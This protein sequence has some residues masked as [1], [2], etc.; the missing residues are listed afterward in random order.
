MPRRA[1]LGLPPTIDLPLRLRLA[2][3]A[4]LCGVSAR[5]VSLA[6]RAPLLLAGMG[7]LRPLLLVVGRR[8]EENERGKN[9]EYLLWSLRYAYGGGTSFWEV[10]R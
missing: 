3:L 8:E 1:R 4:S 10:G 7:K 9:R 5:T 2:S 6:S